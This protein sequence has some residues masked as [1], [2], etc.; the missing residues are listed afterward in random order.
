[1]ETNYSESGFGLK[2]LPVFCLDIEKSHEISLD[3]KACSMVVE[4]VKEKLR[5]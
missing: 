1:M 3:E 2:N 5:S 4:K